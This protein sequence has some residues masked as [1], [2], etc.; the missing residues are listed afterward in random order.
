MRILI[1]DD[2]LDLRE[3]GALF[4]G[5]V[6]G[7]SV[8]TAASGEEAL[9]LLGGEG[10]AFDVVLLDLSMPGLGGS[11]TLEAMRKRPE[12]SGVPVI[13]LTAFGE[14]AL[15]GRTR[16]TCGVIRKPCAPDE[17]IERIRNLIKT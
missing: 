15:D 11:G 8:A 14:E 5:A 10:A 9:E 12:T 16:G 6:P 17:L 2:D 13:L 7:W 3:L 1:V 4:L